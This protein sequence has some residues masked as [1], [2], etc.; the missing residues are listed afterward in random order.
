MS[1][2]RQSEYG[3]ALGMQDTGKSYLLRQLAG[4]NERN[5][6]IP[7]SESTTIWDDYNLVPWE[8]IFEA[9]TQLPAFQAKKVF[10]SDGKVKEKLAFTYAM[11]LYFHHMEGNNRIYIDHETSYLFEI[12]S[13]SKYGL[14]N[15]GLLC[16][17]YTN[18]LPTLQK[19]PSF[20]RKLITNRRDDRRDVWF[21]V[22]SFRQMN[23]DF[24]DW[25]PSFYLKRTSSDLSSAS[26]KLPD[27]LVSL[28]EPIK[29]KVDAISAAGWEKNLDQYHTEFIPGNLVGR[30]VES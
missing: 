20:V 13:N 15:A 23:R 9:S 30:A 28:L 11:G 27:A 22:H 5:L 18:Y 6:V 10:S 21:A 19:L 25:A 24:F 29:Q 7:Q 16:D 14:K 4:I 2:D 8:E 26:G 17:D 3:F 12:I 1:N